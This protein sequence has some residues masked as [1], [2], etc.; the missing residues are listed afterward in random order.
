MT[1][2]NIRELLRQLTCSQCYYGLKIDLALSDLIK[3]IEGIREDSFKKKGKWLV[4]K[5]Y[6]DGIDSVINLLKE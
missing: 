2:P 1:Q 4:P 3:L 6:Q 5:T